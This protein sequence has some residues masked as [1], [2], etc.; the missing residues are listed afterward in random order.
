MQLT[1]A[2]K[3]TLKTHMHAN[4]NTVTPGGEQTKAI[5]T[6]LAQPFD[7]TALQAVADWY[8]GLALAGDLEPFANLN[9][10]NP[11]TTMMQLNSAVKWQVAP[12]GADQPTQT[13]SWLLYLAMTQAGSI[14]MSDPQVRKGILQVFGDV[15][16]GSAANI[17]SAGCGQQAGRRVELALFASVTGSSAGGAF[18]NAAVPVLGFNAAAIINATLQEPDIEDLLLNG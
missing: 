3:T 13:N 7:G 10:W 16:G 1:P 9:C 8:N 18:V 11:R 17:G 2:Q 6:L 5:N 14:D 15:A 12:V 4:A